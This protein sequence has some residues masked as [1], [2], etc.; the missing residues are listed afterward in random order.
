MSKKSQRVI[1]FLFS[2]IYLYIEYRIHTIV[3]CKH[4]LKTVKFDF[5]VA[6]VQ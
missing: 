1:F 2:I 6:S 4:V 5:K 3:I